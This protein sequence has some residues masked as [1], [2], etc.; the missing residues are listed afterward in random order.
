MAILVSG[1]AGFLG[2]KLVQRMVADGKDVVAIARC[3][4]PSEFERHPRVHWVKQDIAVDVLDATF[5][6]S[7]ETIIH[8]AGATLGAGKSE[9]M[10]L[11]ENEQTT[12]RL[13]QS[14]A[15]YVK[16]IIFASS[17]VVYGDVCHL[18]VTEDFSLSPCSA[19]ACSK[20]NSENW[21][22]WFQ[23]RHGGQYI[24]LRFCGF[25]DGGGLV[26]YL[27]DRGL[28]E[29]P[30]ELFSHGNIRR[31]YLPSA[32]AIDVLVAASEYHGNAGFIPVNI[33]SG[34]A[35]SAYELARI[36]CDELKSSSPIERIKAPASQ[37][38]FVFSIEQAKKLFGFNPGSLVDAVRDYA[39]F[40][41]DQ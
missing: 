33:G 9:S 15:G 25:I 1:A 20:V 32:K 17:Q 10:F 37:G 13:L 29:T 41:A 40:R 7:F 35:V 21:L 30:I 3:V 34:Q 6:P 28:T 26:D 24:A 22:R 11:Q 12:V 5:L 4:V 36:V 16:Q 14:L 31:D 27:I 8:V 19:Y 38:D 39:R 18:E 2:R 23:K